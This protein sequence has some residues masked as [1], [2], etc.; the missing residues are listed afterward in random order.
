MDFSDTKT[1]LDNGK[2]EKKINIQT[3][4]QNKNYDVVQRNNG[5]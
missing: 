1:S 5:E 4:I 3:W 2:I